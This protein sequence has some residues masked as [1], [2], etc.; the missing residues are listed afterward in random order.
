MTIRNNSPDSAVKKNFTSSISFAKKLGCGSVM[1]DKN[2]ENEAE[3]DD[4]DLEGRSIVNPY[5]LRMSAY[6]PVKNK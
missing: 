4:N 6:E 1:I 2:K 3:L 5:M